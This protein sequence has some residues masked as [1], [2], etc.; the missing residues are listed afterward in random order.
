MAMSTRASTTP[1]MRTAMRAISALV[2][3]YAGQ[4]SAQTTFDVIG[5]H[6]YSLI[7]LRGRGILVRPIG[8]AAMVEN[9]HMT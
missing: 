9:E 3:V 8:R 5:P 2:L 7:P 4:A 1:R 6:E